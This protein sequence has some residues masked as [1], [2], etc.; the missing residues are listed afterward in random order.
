MT[1]EE[2]DSLEEG[3]LGVELRLFAAPSGAKSIISPSLRFGLPSPKSRFKKKPPSSGFT[4]NIRTPGRRRRAGE[5]WMQLSHDLSVLLTKWNELIDLFASPFLRYHTVESV[6]SEA[7]EGA[8]SVFSEATVSICSD[9]HTHASPDSLSLLPSSF[10]QDGAVSVATGVATT[11]TVSQEFIE[12][13]FHRDS[14]S[15][16]TKN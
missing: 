1:P 8:A 13:K 16:L 15:T 9:C 11:V 3:K 7:T 2:K 14:S 12:I 10:K 4:S 5:M 6:F